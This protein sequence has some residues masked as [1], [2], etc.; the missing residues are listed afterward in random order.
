[1]RRLPKGAGGEMV[2]LL[3]PCPVEI[4]GERV[5]EI[6]RRFRGGRTIAGPVK[7]VPFPAEAD[8]ACLLCPTK[9]SRWN[10]GK[11]CGACEVEHR[12]VFPPL[13][14]GGEELD[15]DSKWIAGMPTQLVVGAASWN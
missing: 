13:I 11:V 4:R 9:L 1:M 14:Y 12:D 3:A 6:R 15:W 7:G 10:T 5:V 2:S 8:R